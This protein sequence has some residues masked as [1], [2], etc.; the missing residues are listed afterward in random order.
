M[1]QKKRVLMNISF[2]YH[3]AM[4]IVPVEIQ[5]SNI[6]GKGVFALRLIPKG[7]IVWQFTEGHDKKIT[8]DKFKWL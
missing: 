3:S 4:Y 5:A 6:E 7:T 2:C 8:R 1:Q